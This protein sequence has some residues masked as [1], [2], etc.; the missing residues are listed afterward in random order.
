MTQVKHTSIETYHATAT[1][2]QTLRDKIARHILRMDNPAH[3]AQVAHDLRLDK[4]T[5]SGRINELKKQSV[6]FIDGH[7]WRFV[8]SGRAKSPI[9]GREAIHYTFYPAV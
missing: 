2:R 1:H 5:V 9:T 8:E 7:K 4:S 3:I 6:V